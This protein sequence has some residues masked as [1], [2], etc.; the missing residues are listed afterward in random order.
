M[1][2]KLEKILAGFPNKK[3]GVIGDIM[4]DHYI[5]GSVERISAEAPVPIISTKKEE[6]VPGGAANTAVNAASLGA[7]VDLSGVVGR[8]AA[9]KKVVEVLSRK[10]VNCRGVFTD[11]SRR[12]TEK[13]RIIAAGQQLVRIDRENTNSIEK[14]LEK[15]FI[16]FIN[17][18]IS[19]WDAI[20]V[21]DYVKGM[22]TPVLAAKV[23]ELARKHKKPVIADI[24][25]INAE[26]FK[27][28][29]LISPNKKE[30]A[31]ISGIK[32]NSAKDIKQIGEALMK[33]MRSAVLLTRSEDGMMLF[34][35]RRPLNLPS[36]APA[37]VDGTGAGDTV[38]ATVALAVTSGADLKQAA[39]IANCAA[40]AVVGKPGTAS[41][42]LKELLN[43]VQRQ[44]LPRAFRSRKT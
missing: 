42:S 3:I 9:A 44:N 35:G 2:I 14:D 21:S 40:G 22:F 25:P 10:G 15:R 19:D 5:T 39:F 31:E 30:A 34:G 27:G 16:N 32:L 4:L 29:T 12:T 11:S 41:V 18:K 43:H 37:V 1:R 13:I 26:Y 33:K 28:A 23:I 36:F 7:K 6:F 20:I 8:D 38:V 24:K 17:S